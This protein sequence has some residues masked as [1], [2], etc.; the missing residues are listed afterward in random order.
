MQGAYKCKVSRVLYFRRRLYQRDGTNY[1]RISSQF[2]WKLFAVSMQSSI[3]HWP[4]DLGRSRIQVLCLQD[5]QCWRRYLFNY[6][7]SH[8]RNHFPE[9]KPPTNTLLRNRLKNIKG[10]VKFE[11]LKFDGFLEDNKMLFWAYVLIIWIILLLE[12]TSNIKLDRNYT[13]SWMKYEMRVRNPVYPSSAK[14]LN[15]WSFP[16]VSFC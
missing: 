11:K 2:P 14:I 4:E 6:F 5:Y 7:F 10:G 15:N 13:G 1:S 9:K 8:T 3:S 12:P 16:K